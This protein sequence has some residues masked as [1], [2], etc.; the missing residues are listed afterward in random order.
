MAT[1]PTLPTEADIPDPIPVHPYF[2]TPSLVLSRKNQ[3]A[4]AVWKNNDFFTVSV[5][6]NIGI[7]RFS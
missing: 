6:S 1:L 3:T 5:F 7:M 4:K 2:T